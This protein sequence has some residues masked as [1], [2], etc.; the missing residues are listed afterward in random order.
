AAPAGVS[1][2]QSAPTW[3]VYRGSGGAIWSGMAYPDQ[4]D[5]S[6]DVI[7]AGAGDDW[8]IGGFGDD[9]AQ[10]GDG[11]DSLQGLGGN[12]ILEGNA[13]DDYLEGDGNPNPNHL[14]STPAA[15][16]GRDFLDGGAG[17][18]T[19]EGDGNADQLFGG[20]GDDLLH[21]DVIA[22]DPSA[23]P[24]ERAL[25]AFGN[26]GDDYLDGE[27]G[28]D[29]LAGDGG[30]DELYGGT[31]DDEMWGD[32][33]VRVLG[34]LASEA[35]AWGNDY[36]DGEDGNDSLMGGGKDDTLYGGM[37]NDSLWG[38]EHSNTPGALLD[39][40]FQGNDYLDGEEGDDYLEGGGKN[41][42]LF[43]GLGND[44]LWGDGTDD[45]VAVAIQGDDYLDGQ[46]GDD[47]LR[48]NGGQ[49]TLIGGAGNDTLDG[50]AGADVLEGGAGSDYYVIDSENDVIIEAADAPQPATSGLTARS[51][52]AAASSV[53]ARDAV[54]ASFSYTLGS[55]LE[56]LLLGGSGSING[57]GNEKGNTILGNDGA[58]V[59]TGG[60]GN[61]YLEGGAGD[62]VYVF[63]AGDGN[64]TIKNTDFLRD[65]ADAS[66]TQAVDTLRFG[67]G[68]SA[69]DVVGYRLGND[70]KLRLRGTQDSVS[71]AG[72]YTAA[73]AQGT[74]EFD[75]KLDRVEFSD[76]TVWDQ[77]M[78]ESVVA[79]QA[80]NHAPVVSANLPNLQGRVDGVLGYAVPAG[81]ITDADPWDS[82]TYS[83]R[84]HDGSALPAWLEFDPQT[85]R[86][87][88]TPVSGSEGFS[89]LT[90]WGTDSYGYA[91][92]ADLLMYVGQANRAPTLVSAVPDQ[93][94]DRRDDF[95]FT[96]T[97]GTFTDPDGEELTYS[98][99]LANGDAL[100]AWLSFDPLTQTF[101]GKPP[102]AGG[103]SVQV[104]AREA[105]GLSTTEIFDITVRPT[106][107][108]MVGTQGNDTLYGGA[109]QNLIQ[110]LGGDDYLVGGS[111][112]DVLQGGEGVDT[113]EGEGGDDTLSG[114]QYMRGGSGHNTYI[115]FDEDTLRALVIPDVAAG[116][117]LVIS[118][119]LRPEDIA[120]T[121]EYSSATLILEDRRTGRQVVLADQEAYDY[122]T[123]PRITQIEFLAD[124]AMRWTADDLHRMANTGDANDNIMKGFEGS[125]N[126]ME[127]GGGNDVLYGYEFNDTLDGGAGNDLLEGGA[128]DDTYLF[129]SGSDCIKDDVGT[130]V[131]QLAAG[132]SQS[133]LRLF[134]TGQT[135]DGKMSVN[136]SLVLAV[137]KSGSR[138]YVDEFFAANGASA[139]SEIRF[140]D[141]SVWDLATVT[142]KAG[143]RV[144][145][146]ADT[147][148]GTAGDDNH[149]VD[150]P[151][152]VIIDKGGYDTVRSTVSYTLP[153]GVEELTLVGDLAFNAT[154]NAGDN[155]LRGNAAANTLTGGGRSASGGDTYYGG[156]GDDTYVDSTYAYSWL[157]DLLKPAT[158]KIFENA[159]EGYDT[160]VTDGYAV[161]LPDNVERMV[162]PHTAYIPRFQYAYGVTYSYRYT[163]NALDNVIDLTGASFSLLPGLML[164]VDGGAG[165]D[166]LIG[167]G[168]D[169]TYVVDNAGDVI[170]EYEHGGNDTVLS[171]VSHTLELNV[172][173]LTLTGNAAINGT[174]N[175]LANL[176]NGNSAA[177]TLTG[178]AGDDTL[179][180]GGGADTYLYSAGWGHDVIDE[181]QSATDS[182]VDAIVFDGSVN[183]GDLTLGRS[184]SDLLLT[185]KL[186]GDSISVTGYFIGARNQVEQIR[187]ADGTAWDFARVEALSSAVIG[188][189]GNDKLSARPAGGLVYGLAGNDTLTG[190]AGDDTLDGGAGVDS[191]AGGTGNDSYVVDSA[192]DVVTEAAGAGTDTVMASATYALGTN[193]ENL[194]LTGTAAINGTGNTV[195]NVLTGNAGNNILN[196]AA[197]ADTMAGGL[198]N[199]TYV[200]D[201]IG[202]VLTEN[203]GEGT[204]LVQSAVTYTLGANVENLTLTGSAG[205][206]GGGNALANLL[207]G[208]GAANTLTGSAGDDTL[209]G[210]AGAD[211]LIGG[212]DDDTYF[213][214]NTG[215][216]VTEVAGGGV[217]TINASISW[218]LGAEVENLNLTG[219]AA[220][221]GTGNALANVINGNSAANLLN[222]NAGAD[223]MAGGAGNDTYVVD[224]AGDVVIELAGG[225][226]D[227]V[228]SGISYVLGAELEKLTLT[229]TAATSATGN[230]LANTLTGNSGANILD[231]GAG[232]DA[233]AGGGGN[234]IYFVD[235][236]GDVVTEASGAG[237]DLV[238]AS[239]TY[240][241]AANVENLTLTGAAAINATGNTLANALVGNSADNVL[242]GGAGKDTMA[243]GDGND[244]YVVDN[245]GDVVIELSGGGTDS[246]NS[247]ITYTLGSELENLVLTGSAA[248]NG[249]GNAS[250]NVINGNSAANTLNGGA[251]N[252]TLS[253]G[254]GKDTLVGGTGD[255]TYFL[256]R[257]FG[258]DTVQ[259]NDATPGNQDMA[260]FDAGI[261]TSQLW[262]KHVG[263]NLE[264]SVIGTSDKLV[265][266]N[267][268][269][270]GKYRVE[271]FKTSNGATLLESQVQNLVSAMAAFAPPATG[272]TTLSASYTASLAPVIAANWH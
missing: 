247:R 156:L 223:T 241:L 154:G 153:T 93:L 103:L 272:Q 59:L 202:D 4:Q 70:I 264:V 219:T 95:R 80:A 88:G 203:P 266:S 167:G 214:D 16:N 177:N 222:G 48:G 18:D 206:N 150:N 157:G 135:A 40:A 122:Q 38:D 37:G 101:S 164:Q 112:D 189:A 191:M 1:L 15:M 33:S 215:D 56:D 75:N 35:A 242:N 7:D 65:T 132:I 151:N 6:G 44:T 217:D 100:P 239:V 204:D 200:V 72:Y 5:T 184:G 133:D 176:I 110:G 71:V 188:T 240:T 261:A 61:D 235:N 111:G 45:I 192:T 55:N 169:T 99:T 195:A 41:D 246:V 145:G 183:A 78:L 73:P 234:D 216:V 136:D 92:G 12:D 63:N 11:N 19:L 105:Q 3:G 89:L 212:A 185:H 201:N 60:L 67:A 161:T 85:L 256:G 230:S 94:A 257:G 58:N 144:T 120:V 243:G 165:A 84:G 142:A 121:R 159:G 190:S 86:L 259:E 137:D 57:T 236:V 51:L 119:G 52:V 43:G 140:A 79:R 146:S 170:V 81:T 68:I 108:P 267:W 23:S 8:V 226:T 250:A 27:N 13:G 14:N 126:V 69:A 123:G 91:V 24:A 198:G 224:N 148:T 168:Y 174:G 107:P 194:T 82:I 231:G 225:G 218:T 160:L 143:A 28:N 116:D 208:N 227:L 10:G 152:D 77:A 64:D 158:P 171:S 263:A 21:G 49:D 50:G 249:T 147:L 106:P 130:N 96:L 172:E 265:V 233:M 248:I 42:T 25:Q 238:K 252:D 17:N 179:A 20:D 186:T 209:D 32:A 213:V 237:T 149:V 29:T 34:A 90:V 221:N 97:P 129:G 141:G 211:K 196:G 181:R 207:T 138:L 166:T 271:E 270:D 269:T 127:G 205:T 118:G 232:A 109:G 117:T 254:A 115:V 39:P 173:N 53:Q 114:G 187:F 2:L 62:D 66:K 178:G 54:E 193:L 31:G 251:G 262:F 125:S 30:N 260:L 244:T 180:G 220:I 228:N 197:G 229:G 9:R 74:L 253:G 162:V 245:T 155:V 199:D 87:S 139:F 47:Y 83:V 36:L 98:A 124:P 131:I 46:D 210:G 163:G 76:G 258:A 134:R 175:A 255:D 268:Y 22:Y 104:T 128:G 26:N 113:V 182:A 102:E